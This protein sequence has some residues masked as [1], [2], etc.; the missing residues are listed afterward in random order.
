MMEFRH[1]IEN[2][3]RVHQSLKTMGN[4]GGDVQHPTVLCREL[5]RGPL[6]ECV[7]VGTEIDDHIIDG[8]HGTTHQLRLFVWPHLIMH[9]AEGTLFLVKRDVALNQAGAKPERL[10]FSSA[11][12]SGE[13]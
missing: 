4:S 12:D 11:P 2:L 3:G 13:E 6:L 10:E 8:A 9:P 5:H 7:G 1:L